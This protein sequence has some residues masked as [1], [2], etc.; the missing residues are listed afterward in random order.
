MTEVQDRQQLAI[1]CSVIHMQ[2]AFAGK[3]KHLRMCLN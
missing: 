2:E 3:H 1:Y